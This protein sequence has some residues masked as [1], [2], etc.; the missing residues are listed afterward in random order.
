MRKGAKQVAQLVLGTRR[1]KKKPELLDENRWT[2]LIEE[3]DECKE[4]GDAPD[5]LLPED[6]RVQLH[7]L[8]TN[9][10]E[11]N[12]LR[13]TIRRVH[14]IEYVVEIKMS[15]GTIKQFGV[16]QTKL[17]LDEDINFPLN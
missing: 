5:F 3:H 1:A 8:H 4:D 12:G 14:K 15:D 11:Y 6:T 13:G 10:S 16:S 17:K 2:N 7:D 9:G